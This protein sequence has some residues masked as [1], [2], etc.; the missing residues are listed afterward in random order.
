MLRALVDAF[1]AG[2]FVTEANIQRYQRILGDA[3]DDI[4]R[5]QVEKLLM[6]ERTRLMAGRAAM[7]HR[8]LAIFADLVDEA[9]A[10][11][12]ADM[13]NIQVADPASGLLH[14]V[15]QHGFDVPFL[16][17]F[18]TVRSGSGSACGA[19]MQQGR[20]IVVADVEQSPIFAGDE[21][22]RVLRA[23]GVR[24]VQSTPV[25]SR[26]GNRLGMISTHWHSGSVPSDEQQRRLD[27][28]VPTVAAA[29]EAAV[30]PAY[31]PSASG[32]MSAIEP[33]GIPQTRL[34]P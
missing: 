7:W 22:G 10:A 12:G 14:I 32:D 30:A 11:T 31:D 27:R 33:G 8:H 20:R 13:G 5:Q 21:S 26:A 25:L 23:A 34:S 1:E 15:G 4:T 17:F 2:T 9:I 6:E 3:P 29:I 24:T 19:A 16:S 18:A 28:M